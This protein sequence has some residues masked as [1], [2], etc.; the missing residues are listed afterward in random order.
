M[1]HIDNVYFLG[2][3]G[4]GMSAL[5]R[6]FNH[7]G[8]SVAGYDLTK[9][10]L[11]EKLVTERIEVSYDENVSSFP[12]RFKKGNTLIVYTP[13]VPLNHKGFQWLKEND[14]TIYKRAQ[15]LGMVC[16]SAKSIAV[17]G[18]HGKTTVSSMVSVILKES[19]LGCGAFLGGILKNYDS[20]LIVPENEKQW[21]VTE[22]DEYD[23]SFLNLSPNMALVTA[24]DPDH[25]DIYGTLEELKKSFSDFV[26]QIKDGGKLIV[27]KDIGI[28]NFNSGEIE[29]FTY[30]LNEEASYYAKNIKAF[31][32]GY[33]FDLATPSGVITNVILN[34]PGIVNVENAVAASA[35]AMEA[36]ASVDDLRNGLSKYQGVTRRFDIRF[37]NE[38]T[39]FIDDY[40]HHPKELEAVISSVKKLY[41]GKK[42]TGVFQPH[43]FTRTRDFAD[44]FAE[45]LDL[46]DMPIVIPIYPAR[47]EPIKG[48]TSEMII[49][50]MKN[51]NV[52]F[53]KM[54]EIVPWILEN[55]S[56]ILMTLGAGSIDNIANEIT[57]ELERKYV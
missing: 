23:R 42:I 36:G 25:L 37:K 11:T 30:S 8:K 57:E 6:Y 3:G 4:I 12:S 33:N 1:Q 34:F 43:L 10:S 56:D 47:E 2:I 32:D 20:N 51:K 27:K 17:A 41:I 24:I 7:L 9:T 35:L 45:S 15:V 13:A 19:S 22:A 50:K 48:V 21:L 46:L 54:N 44:E 14:Y 29:V 28:H 52:I 18:T 40:A 55:E 49:R 5:A 39:L 26:H 38:K 53:L 31:G 16:N